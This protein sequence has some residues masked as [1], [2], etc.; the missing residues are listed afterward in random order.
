MIFITRNIPTIGLTILR[1]HGFEPR[2]YS[3]DEAIPRAEL[4]R[5]V[6]GCR[7]LI[8]LLSD[9]VD[10]EL[11]DAA[12]E[13]LEVVANFA[14]GYDNIDV[15]ACSRRRV[16]VSNTPG[17]LTEATADHAFALM[18]AVARRLLEGHQLVT[19]GGWRGWAPMQLLGR[20]ISG[21]TLG[22]IG[23]GRIGRALARRAR[24]FAMTVLYHNRHRDE[25]FEAEQGVRF[26]P[27]LLDLLQDS[28][29]V[30]IHTPLTTETHHLIGEA[31][32]ESMKPSA[33]LV[34]TA[35][36]PIVDEAALVRALEQRRIWGAGLDVFER[37]PVVSEGL[38]RLPNVVLT[39][40]LGSATERTRDAM[41]RLCA[42]A[43]VAVLGGR[44]VPQLLNPEVL[45]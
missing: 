40:H 30:S 19:S 4:L 29:V 36:G 38:A 1:E 27:T 15:A 13:N 33:I 43:I 35:R 37:E 34:N 23:M 41:A 31:E 26:V 39:P 3:S 2:V 12:G 5:E 6:R 16:V 28:D 9:R 21:Q 7:G 44:R 17:V 42:E 22:I 8:A 11:L 25:A 45:G 24:A 32:L 10:D 20:D 18:L 14:V